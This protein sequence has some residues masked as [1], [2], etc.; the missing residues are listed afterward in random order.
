MRSYIAVFLIVAAT[1]FLPPALAQGPSKTSKAEGAT[2]ENPSETPRVPSDTKTREESQR[3]SERTRTMLIQALAQFAPA[4]FHAYEEAQKGTN[5]EDTARAANKLVL[6]TKRLLPKT[7]PADIHRFGFYARAWAVSLRFFKNSRSEEAKRLIVAQ[8][9]DSLKET[10]D[11][12]V[13]QQLSTL[14]FDYDCRLMTAEV[15][16]LFEKSQSRRVLGAIFRLAY[17]HGDRSDLERM[18]NRMKATQD[19]SLRSMLEYNCDCFDNRLRGVEKWSPAL[20]V[21]E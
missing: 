19:P 2:Q 17:E 9:N 7:E 13:L 4:E 6:A 16:A 5:E 10:S 12:L 1:S 18:R 14:I 8:W 3:E 20:P 21:F 11:V 15:W